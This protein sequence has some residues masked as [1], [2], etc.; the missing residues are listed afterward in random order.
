MYLGKVVERG[1]V[2]EVLKRP[3]HPYTLG[4]LRSL[5]DLAPPGGVLHTI[6]GSV[7]SLTARP[8]GCPFHPRCPFAQ[9]G[10]CDTGPA[11]ALSE[12]KPRHATACLRVHK[13]DELG[14]H[15]DEA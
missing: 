5:P 2:R 10:T 1:P 9:S 8:A 4:L 12:V 15:H 13:I 3:A 7:P 11:P 6:R 14:G